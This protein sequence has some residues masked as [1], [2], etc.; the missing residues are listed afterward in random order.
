M[1]MKIRMK[2]KKRSHRNNINRPWSR[3]R[4]RHI[5]YKLY[6]GGF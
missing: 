4:H 2:T 1:T 3:D 6:H 5:K